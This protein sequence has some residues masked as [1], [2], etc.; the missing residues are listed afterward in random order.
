MACS[1]TLSCELAETTRSKHTRGIERMHLR[2]LGNATF[3]RAVSPKYVHYLL[4]RILEVEGFTRFR[5]KQAIVLRP[6]PKDPLAVARRTN[7]EAK[8]SGGL[9]APVAEKPLHG[10]ATKNHLVLGLLALASG[11]VEW[12]HQDTMCMSAPPRQGDRHRELHET[13]AHG[14]LDPKGDLVGNNIVPAFRGL[15]FPLAH[16]LG[17]LGVIVWLKKG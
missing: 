12:D 6:N 14:V 11:N 16:T 3:N 4:R 5:Y 10:L 13:L 17:F 7:A 2:E 9:L 8:R 1:K 15:A